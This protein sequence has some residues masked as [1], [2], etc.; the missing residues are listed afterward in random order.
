MT[1][2]Q[3]RDTCVWSLDRRH[4]C[5]T[6]DSHVLMHSFVWAYKVVNFLWVESFL[7]LGSIKELPNN[8]E[9]QIKKLK[10]KQS[11]TKQKNLSKA[12]KQSNVIGVWWWFF[13]SWSVFK[14]TQ[15]CSAGIRTCLSADQSSSSTLT[16]SSFLFDPCLIHRDTVMLE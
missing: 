13:G 15:R 4:W 12:K 9:S 11:K 5:V 10:A 1:A 14:V 2:F 7:Q 8:K 16:E 6:I 3:Q